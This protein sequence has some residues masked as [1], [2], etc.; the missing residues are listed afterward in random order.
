VQRLLAQFPEVGFDT[1]VD[2]HFIMCF[3]PHLNSEIGTNPEFLWDVIASSGSTLYPGIRN[4]FDPA[5]GFCFRINLARY[6]KR[7]E[8]SLH[9]VLLALRNAGR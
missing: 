7:F 9:R 4:H 3:I 2:G 6:S 8:Y 5:W 1:N